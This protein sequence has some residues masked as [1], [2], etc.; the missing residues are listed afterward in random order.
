MGHGRGAGS[1]TSF[2]SVAALSA[3]PR[4][5]GN[6]SASSPV[7]FLA[8]RSCSASRSTS[9]ARPY[10]GTR[11]FRFAFIRRPGTVYTIATRSISPHV[12]SRTSAALRLP[13]RRLIIARTRCRDSTPARRPPPRRVDAL[14]QRR[15][16][17]PG[18]LK[19]VVE[20]LGCPM[21]RW[22]VPL[23]G[24]LVKAYTPSLNCR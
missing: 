4:T 20:H 8:P 2:E 18:G 21:V 19:V 17:E 13:A 16:V 7:S 1:R 10:S 6:T 9:T 5:V 15:L 24:F 11:C 22:D 3:L 23:A 14:E 12:A